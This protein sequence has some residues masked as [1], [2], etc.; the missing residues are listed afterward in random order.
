MHRFSA[1]DVTLCFYGQMTQDPWASV[2]SQ[3]AHDRHSK[4]IALEQKA[5]NMGANKKWSERK[6]LV[7]CNRGKH[8]Q[9]VD[10]AG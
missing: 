7:L 2:N 4:Q 1:Q 3:G 10:L 9:T 6:N 8:V 5:A